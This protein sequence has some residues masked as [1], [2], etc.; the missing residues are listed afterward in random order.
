MILGVSSGF[1]RTLEI[2]GVG[3]RAE[4]S[5]QIWSLTWDFHIR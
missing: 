4:M 3:Y 2:D 5:G 1:T